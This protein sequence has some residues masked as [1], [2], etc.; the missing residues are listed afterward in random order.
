MLIKEKFNN[1]ILSIFFWQEEE[2]DPLLSNFCRLK[3]VLN[4]VSGKK[5][6]LCEHRLTT[7]KRGSFSSDKGH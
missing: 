3:E 6:M 1:N 2:Q 5:N 4:N 7:E